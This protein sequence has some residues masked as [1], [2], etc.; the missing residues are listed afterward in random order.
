M[1]LPRILN[2]RWKNVAVKQVFDGLESELVFGLRQQRKKSEILNSLVGEWLINGPASMTPD[3]RKLVT[4]NRDA[5]SLAYLDFIQPFISTM[6][7]LKLICHTPLD[8]P[9]QTV[10]EIMM[11]RLTRLNVLDLTLNAL[12]DF[13]V[14]PVQSDYFTA[15]RHA[16]NLHSLFIQFETKRTDDAYVEAMT[17]AILQDKRSRFEQLRVHAAIPYGAAPFVKACAMYKNLKLLDVWVSN[18][19]NDLLQTVASECKHMQNLH[20]WHID[21]E[22]VFWSFELRHVKSAFVNLLELES[23]SLTNKK[24]DAHPLVEAE[25]TWSVVYDNKKKKRQSWDVK[26]TGSANLQLVP[27]VSELP[28]WISASGPTIRHLHVECLEHAER[29]AVELAKYAAGKSLQFN[30]VRLIQSTPILTVFE[31]KWTKQ[32]LRDLYRGFDNVQTLH[33]EAQAS[34]VRVLKDPRTRKLSLSTLGI[35]LSHLNELLGLAN[36]LEDCAVCPNPK[37]WIGLSI[38]NVEEFGGQSMITYHADY[39]GWTRDETK[40]VL[41]GLPSLESIV[42]GGEYDK[43]KSADL[44]DLVS[45]EVSEAEIQLEKKDIELGQQKPK[46]TRLARRKLVKLIDQTIIYN[47]E[48]KQSMR[49]SQLPAAELRYMDLYFHGHIGKNDLAIFVNLTICRL[50]AVPAHLSAMRVGML[51][52]RKI[53]T[54]HHKFPSPDRG[55]LIDDQ[56]LL[57]FLK[58]NRGMH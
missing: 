22:L 50:I 41:D 32:D 30:S 34:R 18:Q 14:H 43:R 4:T 38:D 3:E 57:H 52:G 27:P 21:R 47:L 55:T 17:S 31:S 44:M 33:V 26:M 7:S 11:K 40:K 49:L 8:M 13:D 36:V 58:R 16:E 9:S 46:T 45:Y 35:E 39:V 10:W 5:N 15:I 53:P 54:P 56:A 25:A 23:L 20:I 37:S 28:E 24:R 42:L 6:R 51:S 19:Q 29:F 48:S 12:D 1:I 2:V